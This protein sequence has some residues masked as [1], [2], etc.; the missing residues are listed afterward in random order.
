MYADILAEWLSRHRHHVVRTA[1][2]YW[3][4]ARRHVFRA[5]ASIV[6]SRSSSREMRSLMLRRVVAALRDLTPLEA[7]SGA[8]SQWAVRSRSYNSECSLL[9]SVV[10]CV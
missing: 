5:S 7:S 10:V 2:N 9:R 4:E 3:H 8:V 6:S 1:S